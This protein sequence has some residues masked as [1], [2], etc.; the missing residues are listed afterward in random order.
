MELPS[1]V[2]SGLALCEDKFTDDEFNGLLQHVLAVASQR[3]TPDDEQLS[4]KESKFDADSK[5][6]FASALSLVL[7]AA[8]HDATADELRSALEDSSMS[9]DRTNLFISLIVQNKT[10]IRGQLQR[11]NLAFPALVGVEWRL[12]Y[13]MKSDLFEQSRQPLFFVTLF[14]RLP[15]STIA[16][17]TFT[18]DFVQLEDLLAKLKDSVRQATARVHQ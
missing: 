1:S 16:L 12:D 2:T 14:T 5:T 11:L 4:A 9:E 6:A 13:Y 18:C 10:S 15:D 8:R 17:K 3:K 7:E